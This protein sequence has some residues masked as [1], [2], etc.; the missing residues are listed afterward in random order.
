MQK[1]PYHLKNILREHIYSLV[2]VQ[3][4]DGINKCY[5]AQKKV[6]LFNYIFHQE[7]YPTW[8][9]SLANCRSPANHFYPRIYYK[10]YTDLICAFSLKATS[11][12]CL[13]LNVW[14]YGI[15]M[16]NYFKYN[17]WSIDG[18]Q[19]SKEFGI[20]NT[21]L[22]LLLTIFSKISLEDVATYEK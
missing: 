19:V 12:P 21:Y 9:S 7:N 5:L 8:V 3:K 22:W 17:N 16:K 20:L 14:E 4:I 6:V 1:K 2:K 18:T 13:I 11:T 10:E 15:N